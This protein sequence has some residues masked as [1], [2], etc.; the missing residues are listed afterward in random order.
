MFVLTILIIFPE[1]L[2]SRKAFC[3]T[4]LSVENIP[5]TV[6]KFCVPCDLETPTVVAFFDFFIFLHPTYNDKSTNILK[7]TLE[8]NYI[9]L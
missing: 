8:I 1:Q 5:E 7:E 4:A 9:T 6:S 3:L 2:H